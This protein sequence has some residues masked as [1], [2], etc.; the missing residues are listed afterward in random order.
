M[1]LLDLRSQAHPRTP[2]D[3]VR[4]LGT[5]EVDLQF[6]AGVWLF[7]EDDGRF[8]GEAVGDGA[9]RERLRAAAALVPCGLVGLEARYPTD[10]HGG[11]LH[12]W[13]DGL[14]GTGL[15]VVSVA[16]D[17]LACPDEGTLSSS[18]A[19]RRQSAVSRTTEALQLARCVGADFAGVWTGLDAYENPFGLDVVGARRRFADGLAEAMDAAPGVRV[20]VDMEPF[21]PRSQGLYG[22]PSAAVM[23]GEEVERRLDAA[24]NRRCLRDEHALVTLDLEMGRYMRQG[25]DLPGALSWPLSQGRL[26]HVH[27]NS[28]PLATYEPVPGLDLSDPTPMEAGVYMLKMHGYSGLFGIDLHS[29]GAS[30][31]VAVRVAMDALRAANDRVNALDHARVV[32]SW[33]HPGR[34]V[35]A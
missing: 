24:D 30:G 32:E 13:Q 19:R 11:N 20:A 15:R 26:A 31:T 16:A 2:D 22:H 23:L 34:S 6:T 12:V 3:L 29:G 10:I 14:R 18:D 1:P 27:W 7:A 35:L 4:H 28:W 17:P 33:G 5:F 8:S 25:E 21:E 9:L